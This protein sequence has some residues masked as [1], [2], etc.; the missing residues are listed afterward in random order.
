MSRNG[1]PDHPP[2]RPKP[3]RPK[4]VRPIPV[5]DPTP[6]ADVSSAAGP[7]PVRTG[8]PSQPSLESPRP[9][10]QTEL[11]IVLVR[12]KGLRT[13]PAPP[14]AAAATRWATDA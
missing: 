5:A 8:G 4:R 1:S 13:E 12:F 7:T 11:Q 6:V 10:G 9:T 14:A 2:D 3:V